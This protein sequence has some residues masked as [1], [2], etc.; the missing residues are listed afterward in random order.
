M[1]IQNFWV[2]DHRQVYLIGN[3]VVWWSSTAAIVAYVAVRGFL[4]LRA[5]RGYRDL[6][7]REY[8]TFLLVP[9][10]LPK[11]NSAKFIYS[12]ARIL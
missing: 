8:S 11:Q 3:P 10:P 5:Q 9:P 1:G 7:Q 4:V 6:H 2:K 12:Q